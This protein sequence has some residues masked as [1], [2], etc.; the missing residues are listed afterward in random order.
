MKTTVHGN[1]K[2]LILIES[3]R[4]TDESNCFQFVNGRLRYGSDRN[5]ILAKFINLNTFTKVNNCIPSV[6]RQQP[7]GGDVSVLLPLQS[8]VLLQLPCIY[9]M[10]GRAGSVHIAVHRTCM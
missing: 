6:Y 2:L 1:A 8:S 4:W 5:L 10:R 3:L 7:I 9:L